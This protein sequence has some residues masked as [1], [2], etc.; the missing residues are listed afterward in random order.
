MKLLDIGFINTIKM[1]NKN[2]TRKIKIL[3][4]KTLSNKE[5]NDYFGLHYMVQARFAAALLHYLSV[6]KSAPSP[7]SHSILTFK[8][9]AKS[10]SSASHT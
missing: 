1:N 7:H 10:N 6:C 8:A 3:C 4:K 9:L 2:I 5:K